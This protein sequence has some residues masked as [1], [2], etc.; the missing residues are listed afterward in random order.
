MK[1]QFNE[2]MDR[3]NE[4][5]QEVKA[6]K[7]QDLLIADGGARLEQHVLALLTMT[8]M[9][10]SRTS[11]KID[12]CFGADFLVSYKEDDT[13]YS[14]YV[15]VTT[16]KGKDIMYLQLNGSLVN[17]YNESFIAQF[18]FADI[19]FGLKMKHRNRFEYEKPVIVMVF[20]NINLKGKG[21]D[22]TD[23][24]IRLMETFI[25][26]LNAKLVNEYGCNKRASKIFNI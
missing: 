8:D 23:T 24:E 11:S 20:R 19:A 17:D 7:K 1:L 4:H 22:V 18:G 25:K 6:K 3:Y 21:I 16:N 15:D 14:A 5:F 9:N 12:I 10:V 26:A 2:Y 13:N